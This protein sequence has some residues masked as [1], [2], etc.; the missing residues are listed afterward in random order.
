[1]ADLSAPDDLGLVT[2]VPAM[3]L[4]TFEVAGSRTPTIRV[5]METSDGRRYFVSLTMDA[6]KNMISG[7]ANWPPMTRFLL[8]RGSPARLQ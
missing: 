3:F 1:V 5:Q 4:S 2:A 8:E 6:A 7:L